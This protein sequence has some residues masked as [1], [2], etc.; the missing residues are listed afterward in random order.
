MVLV[1]KKSLGILEYLPWNCTMIKFNN[2]MQ[3]KLVK[4]TNKNIDQL[5]LDLSEWW[6]VPSDN[7]SLI[8]KLRCY[9]PFFVPVELDGELVD[10]I[11]WNRNKNI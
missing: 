7:T 9:Y 4:I 5:G 1:H 3:T 11:R 2:K 6:I 8:Y 10:I